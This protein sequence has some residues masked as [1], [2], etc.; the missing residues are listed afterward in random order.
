MLQLWTH[1]NRFQSKTILIDNSDK[2]ADFETI[3]S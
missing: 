2:C 3:L 1:V